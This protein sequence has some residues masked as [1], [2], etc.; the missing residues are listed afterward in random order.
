[1][2]IILIV[3]FSILLFQGILVVFSGVALV[4]SELNNGFSLLIDVAS[5]AA[6]VAVFF[7]AIHTF[8]NQQKDKERALLKNQK[9]SY[10]AQKNCAKTKQDKGKDSR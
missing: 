7:W 2:R 4:F 5:K 8:I 3:F 10:L 6:A 9:S 1:M